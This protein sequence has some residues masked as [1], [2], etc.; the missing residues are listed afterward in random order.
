MPTSPA[1]S[2]TQSR[3]T[4]PQ[5]P[6][7]PERSVGLNARRPRLGDQTPHTQ[8]LLKTAAAETRLSILISHA[9]PQRIDFTEECKGIYIAACRETQ[10]RVQELRYTRSPTYRSL[11]LALVRRRLDYMCYPRAQQASHIAST[12]VTSSPPRGSK[13]SPCKDCHA[14]RLQLADGHR[15]DCGPSRRPEAP[16]QLRDGRSAGS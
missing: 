10:A 11:I 4:S 3:T 9:F 7:T 14:L 2:T 16:S 5:T 15:R 6:Q 13:R 12:K 1:Q 8:G